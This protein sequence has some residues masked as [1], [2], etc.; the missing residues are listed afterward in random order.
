V[1]TRVRDV[2]TPEP[3]TVSSSASLDEV[4]RLMRDNDIGDVVVVEADAPVGIVTDRDIVIRGV[5]D[6]PDLAGLTAGDVCSTSVVVVNPDTDMEQAIE[7]MREHAIRRLPVVDNDVV[8]GV[9]SLGD[10]AMAGDA[11][12]ALTEISQA[13]PDS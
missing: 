4:A 10:V 1:A 5:A 7:L 13:P 3:I 11:D 6:T 2:M 12:P 9:V 8:V